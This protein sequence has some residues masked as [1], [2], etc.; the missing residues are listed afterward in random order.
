MLPAFAA[1]VIDEPASQFE[2]PGSRTL[3]R[4]IYE[5]AAAHL[6]GKPAKKDTFV[7][8]SRVWKVEQAEFRD[9]VG[10]WRVDAIDQGPV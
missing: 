8:R 1:I 5:I 7:H 6:P 10:A 3:R 2:E 4:R 9:P